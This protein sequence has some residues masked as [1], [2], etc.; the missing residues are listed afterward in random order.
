VSAVVHVRRAVKAYGSKQAL[1]GLELEVHEGE[2]FGLLGPNGAGKTTAMLVIAGLLPLDEGSVELFGGRSPKDPGTRALI[3]YAPQALALYPELTA[4]ENIAFFA[5][6]YGQSGAVLRTSVDRALAFAGLSQ[7]GKD[8]VHTFSGGMKRRL[9][10]ASA[11]VHGPKLLLLDEPTAGVDPQSR[12][13]VLSSLERLRAG[14]VTIIYS[15]HYIEEVE[16]FC[17]RIAIVDAGR[18]V[19]LGTA[20]ELIAEHGGAER[21]V[22]MGANLETAFLKLTGR[23]LR[24]QP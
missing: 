7:H 23:T 18:V 4:A 8:R 24:D 14:G 15:S 9:N 5:R 19:A 17:S 16:R 10:L 21:V 3:G 12:V 1:T 20:P 13:H 6:L 22:V 2:A 11:L